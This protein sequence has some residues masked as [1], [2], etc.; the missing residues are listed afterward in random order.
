VSD[1][2]NTLSGTETRGLNELCSSPRRLNWCIHFPVNTFICFLVHSVLLLLCI[3]EASRDP[4]CI[5][6]LES[7]FNFPFNLT[8]Y[9][10]DPPHVCFSGRSRSRVMR[11]HTPSFFHHRKGVARCACETHALYLSLVSLSPR[12]LTPD[13]LQRVLELWHF[14]SLRARRARSFRGLPVGPWPLARALS[15]PQCWRR[16]R[17]VV[18][19]P[20]I[21]GYESLIRRP[22]ESFDMSVSHTTGPLVV[23]QD[24]LWLSLGGNGDGVLTG[25]ERY[26]FPPAQPTLGALRGALGGGG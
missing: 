19:E 3:C 26:V 11:P 16:R 1:D 2:A 8:M 15:R 9:A 4:S 13:P 6:C 7:K 12:S 18:H 25:N 14:P 23:S 5:P 22:L 21:C 10:R 17:C 24:P 20:A